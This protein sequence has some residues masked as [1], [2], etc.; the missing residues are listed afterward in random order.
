M[1][2]NSKSTALQFYKSPLLLLEIDPSIWYSLYTISLAPRA[3]CIDYTVHTRSRWTPIIGIMLVW[4]GHV[5]TT[6]SDVDFYIKTGT[7]RLNK[8]NDTNNSQL[9][10]CCYPGR[11]QAPSGCI[12]LLVLLNDVK[13]SSHWVSQL[14]LPCWQ[15]PNVYPNTEWWE[16]Q[17][18]QGV[19]ANALRCYQHGMSHS[20]GAVRTLQ[21]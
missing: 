13:Y 3:V 21:Q 2:K 16:E 14:S 15:C 7:R 17:T 5:M 11:V 18:K 6:S 12:S 10:F 8:R 1:R 9:L 19:L 20:S 4:K